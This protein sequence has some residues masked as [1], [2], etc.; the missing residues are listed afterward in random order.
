[1]ATVTLFL[2]P[3]ATPHTNIESRNKERAIDMSYECVS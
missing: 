3:T 2:S 1:M